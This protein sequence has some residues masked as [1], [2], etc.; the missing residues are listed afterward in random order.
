MKTYIL[1]ISLLISTTY[2]FAQTK[3][4][5]ALKDENNQPIPF[6]D[7]YFTN[8]S[9]GTTSDM[10]GNFTLESENDY[11]ELTISFIGYESRVI[12]LLEKKTMGIQ[13]VLKEEPTSLDEVYIVGKPKKRLSKK[14][15]P[16]YRILKKIWENKKRNGVKLANSY[17]YDKYTTVEL[18]FDNMDSTFV[19]KSLKEDYNAIASKMKINTDNG[20]YYLPI[21]LTETTEKVYGDNRLK[22]ERIDIVGQRKV[23]IEQQ[24]KILERV[25]GVFK[26]INIYENDIAIL[27]KNFVSPI[28]TEG[29]G[30]YDYVLSDSTTVE[31]KKY[32]TIYFFPRQDGD[33]AFQ[34]S[35]TIADENFSIVDIEMKTLKQMNLNFVR[36]F[37]FKKTFSIKNDSIYIPQ[38]NE[39]KGDFTL[40]TK[41]EEEK[42]I[43]VNKN[44]TFSNYEFDTI[45]EPSFYDEVIEQTKVDQFKK[46]D[47]YWKKNQTEDIAEVYA[48]VD[49]V[50]DSKK[51]NGV[52]NK[53]YILSDGYINITDGLQIGSIWATT[54]RNDVEGYRARMGFRTFKTYNDRLRL[55]GFLAYGFT[56]KKLK[57]GLEARYLLSN[58]P[59]TTL[60][61][62]YLNDN[63]QMGLIT[64][65]GTHLIPEA[66]KG[67][68][69]L[70]GRGSNF[71]LSRIQ[72]SMLRFDWEAKKNLHFGI[73]TSHNKIESAAP[74][75]F[76]LEYLDKISNTIQSKTT[77]VTTDLYLSFTPGREVSGYGVDEKVG[78][79][80]HPS[81]LLN[82]RR[83][84]KNLL[85]GDFNYNRIQLIYN[86]PISLGKFGIFDATLGAGKTFEAV[87]L[88][89]LTAVSSNQTYFLVPNTFALLDYYDFVA[90]TYFEGHFEHHFN[91]L[92]LNRIPLL[93]EL[94]LR[95]LLTFRGVYGT[96]SDQSKDINRSSIIYT[97]PSAKPY[98]EYGFG[99]ENIG[100]GNIR[101][102]RV[103]F[104]W[105]NDFQNFNG[106]VNPKFGIRVGIKTVF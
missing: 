85:G 3:V 80:S 67:S 59:R 14:E 66:D 74:D 65:N 34:G 33:F 102:F 63:E 31:N 13:I 11:P 96:I 104:I 81:L 105:R 92:L 103:D 15:N 55:E 69:A 10:D 41:G 17:Q 47:R 39:Y 52:T 18:G 64:F 58:N 83:G 6:A 70:F 89:L 5:G 86:H 12:S 53:I 79:K 8:S 93:K 94:K 29:F 71:F 48:V 61:A 25:A 40:L 35:M 72:K 77:D 101:P 75:L 54:A 7:V 26:E 50:K 37:E 2:T 76:S 1:F 36:S 30:T 23:G 62:A 56:D 90:D 38:K 73:T 78:I 20:T 45:K 51:V 32:Y 87:P 27:N 100:I 9:V 22:K 68:K 28:S 98:Y 46:N 88:S 43:F 97:A 21:Q 42:G 19:K 57:Y 95:S 24:G 84:Y 49:K 60:S 91:G 106:S 82:Y 44:E 99:F 4:Q 16:A